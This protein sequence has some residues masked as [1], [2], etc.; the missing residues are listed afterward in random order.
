LEA[1][2]TLEPLS[3]SLPE[4][5]R[6]GL[7]V[8]RAT[9]W[10]V[11]D[12][13]LLREGVDPGC[14]KEALEGRGGCA[15]ERACSSLAV[16]ALYEQL[17][18]SGVK[19]GSGLV[20]DGSVVDASHLVRYVVALEARRICRAMAGRGSKPRWTRLQ[21]SVGEGEARH[22]F[23]FFRAAEV[24]PSAYFSA[25]LWL[26][27]YESLQVIGSVAGANHRVAYRRLMRAAREA[28]SGVEGPE[29]GE[30]VRG[31][32]ATEPIG[33][34]VSQATHSTESLMAPSSLEPEP[35][36]D[37]YAVAEA[38]RRLIQASRANLLILVDKDSPVAVSHPEHGDIVIGF[39]RPALL[40]LR[41]LAAAIP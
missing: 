25:K 12:P 24:K 30:E 13:S 6:A 9:P 40:E 23:T 32:A 29:A 35:K 7:R 28:L 16:S 8:Y 15:G 37:A 39:R 1:R 17:D 20:V 3:E 34:L 26:T 18:L 22:V 11:E 10:R 2:F 31:A 21:V 41:T 5:L 33:D 27:A 36:E 14:L 19:P 38:L 4:E